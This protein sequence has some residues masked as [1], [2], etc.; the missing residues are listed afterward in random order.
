MSFS[1]KSPATK[2][3][4]LHTG[5]KRKTSGDKVLTSPEEKGKAGELEATR[6]ENCAITMQNNK[7][8]FPEILAE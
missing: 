1:Q 5:S 8:S 4:Q 2:K 6:V 3:N 7:A